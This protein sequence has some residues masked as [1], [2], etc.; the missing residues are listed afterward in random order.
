[1]RVLLEVQDLSKYFFDTVGI[2]GVN[3]FA[4][5]ENVSFALEHKKTLAIIG[6]NGSGKSTLE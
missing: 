3:S 6:K 2:W 4:A 5:I 1:M